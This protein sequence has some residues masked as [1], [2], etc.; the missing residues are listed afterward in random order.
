MNHGARLRT[1]RR[2]AA[3]AEMAMLAP[4]LLVLFFGSVE[5]GTYFYNEHKLVKSV[6]DGARFAARQQFSNYSACTGSL[7]TSGTAG[8]AYERTKLIVRKGKLDS[9]APD[10]LPNWGGV[11]AS[12][13][14]NPAGGCLEMTMSCTLDLDPTTNSMNL[15]GIY[16]NSTTGAPTVVVSAR[17][18]YLSVLGTTLGFDSTGIFLNAR[19]SAAVAG[20]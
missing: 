13:A 6:R 10:L 12:C 5:L 17:I 19:Q 16:T 1:D 3:A 8:S 9:S 11:T 15:G 7:P 18:P 14:G 2:G 20:L 4:I